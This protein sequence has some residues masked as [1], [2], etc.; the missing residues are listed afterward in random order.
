MQ[1]NPLPLRDLHMP[2]PISWWPLAAGWWVILAVVLLLLSWLGYRAL[3]RYRFNAAQ[4]YALRTLDSI[5]SEFKA[6][7]NAVSLGKSISSLLRRA[8][9]AYA[10]RHEIAGLTGADWLTWLD[11]D[12]PVPYFQTDGGKTLL[13]LPY[14]D[15]NAD[16]SHIDT[17][18]LLSAARLRLETPVG[19]LR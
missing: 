8:M 6:N 16:L 4:R 11:R 7:G 12:L 19:G 13:E 17:G 1:E 18:A 3:Q 5:E 9:L 15:P 2:E 10:P 14:R